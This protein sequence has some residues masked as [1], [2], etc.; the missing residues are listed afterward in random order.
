MSPETWRRRAGRYRVLSAR[1]GEDQ[2]SG[3]I[4]ALAAAAEARLAESKRLS[5]DAAV[6]TA[7]TRV[8]LAEIDTVLAHGNSRPNDARSLLRRG[9]LR[10]E[11]VREAAR[12]CV[13]ESKAALGAE[14]KQ[15]VASRAFALAELAE[16]MRRPAWQPAASSPTASFPPQSRQLEGAVEPAPASWADTATI[17]V[18]EDDSAVRQRLRELLRSNG[19]RVAAFPSG[20]SFLDAYQARFEG[21]LVIDASGPGMKGIEVLSELRTRGSSLAVLMTSA[22][23]NVATAVEAMK[24][25]ARDFIEKPFDE[26][27]ILSVIG[28]ALAERAAAANTERRILA[29]QRL[30][31]LTKRQREILDLIVA[32]HPNKK[33]AARLGIDRRTV[34]AHRALLMKKMEAS[35]FAELVRLT[36]AAASPPARPL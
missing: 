10:A 30:A 6:L 27:Q 21:C 7:M 16:Q 8:L 32:G 12:L 17:F 28:Q 33:V 26:R 13:A 5:A 36:L 11:D 20:E 22:E 34:E 14:M 25:G 23:R 1:L 9:H 4:A 18:V 3:R 2:T 15:A 24:A 19:H 29:V 35:S 31:S